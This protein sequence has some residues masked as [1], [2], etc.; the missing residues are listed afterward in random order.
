MLDILHPFNICFNTLLLAASMSGN[1]SVILRFHD[2][3]KKRIFL[4]STDT[5]E[6]II[7]NLKKE[8]TGATIII[9][10][11]GTV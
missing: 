11:R 2:E 1:S 10:H 3:V 8:G 7:G 5:V 6:D 4:K 9:R